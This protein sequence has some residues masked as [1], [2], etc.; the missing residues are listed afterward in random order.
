MTVYFLPLLAYLLGSI[1]AAIVV[2]RAMGLQDPRSIGSGNPG[3]TN[4]LRFGGKKA[5]AI[6]L[7]GDVLKGIIPVAITRALSDDATLIALVAASAF[8]GHLFPIFFG[9]R[10]GKGV[11]TAFGALLGMSVW[12]GLAV[13]ATWA[14]AALAL[15]YSSLAAITAS[16]LAPVYVWLWLPEPIYLYVALFMAALLLWRHRTNMHNLLHGKESKIG[17]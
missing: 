11:A 12:V 16:L 5:A 10:G 14:V 9:F 4:V 13:A 15:R 17:R 6:T 7:A 1:S 8:L 2:T 3:A